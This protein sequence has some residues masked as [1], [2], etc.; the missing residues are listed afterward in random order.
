MK[1]ATGL[2]SALQRNMYAAISLAIS[3]TTDAYQRPYRDHVVL[4]PDKR[5]L[6][7]FYVASSAN[8]SNVQ[9]KVTETF[10]IS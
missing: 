7:P 4:G 1:H 3:V 6:G 5:D 10:P 2:R 9:S 8:K